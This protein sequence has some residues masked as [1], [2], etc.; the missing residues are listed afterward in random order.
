MINPLTTRLIIADRL[1][2]MNE[3]WQSTRKA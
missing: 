1:V 3:W 2:D